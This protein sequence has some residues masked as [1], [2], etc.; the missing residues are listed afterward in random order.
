MGV[1]GPYL[2]AIDPPAAVGLCCFC[3]GSEQVGAGAWLAHADDEAQF[4]AANAGQDVLLDVLRCVFEQNRAAL[5]VGNKVQAH[6]G[7]GDAEFFSDDVTLEKIALTAAVFFW[8]GHADPA[9][10]ADALAE[11]A[12]VAVA[13]PGPIRNERAGR[14]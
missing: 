4:A 1:A 13:V 5:P 9:L 10:G 12:I 3:F 2:G 14:H 11:F 7:V 8:P 6:R